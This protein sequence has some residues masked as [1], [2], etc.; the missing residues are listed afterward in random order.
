M[1]R[2]EIDILIR[3]ATIYDGTGK[4]SF[5]ADVAIQKDKIVHICH[6]TEKA[7]KIIEAKNL[8]FFLMFFHF[9]FIIFWVVGLPT[10][11]GFYPNGRCSITTI[12]SDF[13]RHSLCNFAIRGGIH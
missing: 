11:F 6:I 13:C 9:Y 10:F 5:V 7:K 2:G 8:I 4:K 3:G 1:L 12:S